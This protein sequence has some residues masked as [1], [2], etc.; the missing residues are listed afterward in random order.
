MQRHQFL[1]PQVCRSFHCLLFLKSGLLQVRDKWETHAGIF[2]LFKVCSICK[3]DLFAVYF[4][5][6]DAYLP[7]CCAFCLVTHAVGFVSMEKSKQTHTTHILRQELLP[8]RQLNRRSSLVSKD[9]VTLK[10]SVAVDS[11]AQDTQCRQLRCLS[12]WRP[13]SKQS[14]TPAVL[15]LKLPFT[16]GC[17]G[18]KNKYTD[19]VQPNI[20][21]KGLYKVPKVLQRKNRLKSLYKSPPNNSSKL[22]C[23]SQNSRGEGRVGWLHSS[24]RLKM[25]SLTGHRCTGLSYIFR[26]LASL[27]FQRLESQSQM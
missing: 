6:T 5:Q 25:S 7:N 2:G 18:K 11:S 27:H 1:Q 12:Y 13:L 23:S 9:E 19:K 20:L 4:S 22:A 24:R 8:A 15:V 3:K 16:P 10:A 14:S 26:D 17:P 21:T